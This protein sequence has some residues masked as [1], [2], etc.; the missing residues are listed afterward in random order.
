MLE[1][2]SQNNQKIKCFYNLSRKL[3][4]E[5]ELDWK[6]SSMNNV[7]LTALLFEDILVFLEKVRTESSNDEKRRYLLRPLIYSIISK[8]KQMFTPVIPISCINSFRSMHDKRSFHIVAIIEDPL[9]SSKHSSK[10]IQTQMLFILIAKSGDERNKWT[11]YLQELTGKMLQIAANVEVTSPPAAAQTLTTTTSLAYLGSNGAETQSPT[12]RSNSV[13]TSTLLNSNKNYGSENPS[14]K[15]LN[16][17]NSAVVANSGIFADL[18]G[19]SK[20]TDD[21]KKE[22]SN[23]LKGKL[24]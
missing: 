17:S 14:G 9:K 15:V 20:D 10:P 24:K 21:F 3:I 18:D 2:S 13:S 4:Y 16:K 1:S 12:L 7:K 22:S 11:T 8:T 5:G 6:I 23:E 19:R